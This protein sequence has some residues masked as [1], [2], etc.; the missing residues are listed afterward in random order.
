MRRSIRTGIA[1]AL[2]GASVF[3]G[4]PPALA[5]PGS[6]SVVHIHQ[7]TGGTALSVTGNFAWHNWSVGIYDIVLTV[8]PGECAAVDFKGF[9]NGVEWDA[10]GYAI[11]CAENAS[12]RVLNLDAVLLSPDPNLG[13]I[14]RVDVIAIDWD[15]G[16]STTV[17]YSR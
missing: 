3:V 2:V 15:H 11:I 17:S 9:H 16:G 14:N 12:S 5:S 4:A 7:S 8:K 10:Q 1:T 6:F 13:A